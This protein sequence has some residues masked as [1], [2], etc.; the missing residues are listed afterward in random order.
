MM[1]HFQLTYLA[2]LIVYAI[3][4]L[5]RFHRHPLPQRNEYEIVILCYI[6]GLVA[7]EFVQVYRP[8]FSY[9]YDRRQNTSIAENKILFHAR[10]VDTKIMSYYIN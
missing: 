2:F 10:N 9:K 5:L 4:I 1:R 7:E 3:T 8:G 6:C